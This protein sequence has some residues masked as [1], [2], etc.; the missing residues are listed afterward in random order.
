MRAGSPAERVSNRLSE[1]HLIP[2][3][4]EV[5]RQ[6]KP[7]PD[8]REPPV[9]EAAAPPPG[10][11]GPRA[12]AP[13]PPDRSKAR[14]Y[15][16]PVPATPP[17]PPMTSDAMAGQRAALP[18]AAYRTRILDTLAEGQVLVIEG[19]TGCGK[20]TQVPQ[21]VLEEAAQ[22]QVP[23]NIICTQVYPPSLLQ[24]QPPSCPLSIGC[25]SALPLLGT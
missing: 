14:A 22:K 11:D 24:R 13:P 9:R 5:R 3:V 2:D 16:A 20:T 15:R 4:M 8:P 17:P 23:A 12:P 7:H 21:F 6:P 18:A 10:Q 25:G 19:E 1:T